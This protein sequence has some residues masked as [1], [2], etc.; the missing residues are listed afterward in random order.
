MGVPLKHTSESTTGIRLTLYRVV[1]WWGLTVPIL[2]TGIM[3]FQLYMWSLKG[4]IIL[5][6]T[7]TTHFSLIILIITT[8]LTEIVMFYSC[9]KKY[10]KFLDVSNTLER[11]DR[12]LQLAPPA[13]CITV[14]FTTILVVITATPVMAHI[15]RV[16]MSL[17][18]EKDHEMAIRRIMTLFSF[19]ILNC[20]QICM[21]FQFHEVTQCIAKRFILVN[22]SIKQELIIKSYR[23]SVRRRNPRYINHRED[24][25]SS[26]KMKS[27]MR[28]YQMLRDAVDQGNAFY[29]DLLMSSVFCKFVDVTIELFTFSCY[30]VGVS[31]ISILIIVTTLCH[32]C[33]LVLVVSSSSDVTQAADETAPIICKL[34]NKNLDAGLRKQL[35]TFLMQLSVH[36]VVFSARGCFKINRRMLTTLA[37]TKPSLTLNLGTNG[38]KVTSEPPPMAGQAGRL[39][40]QDRSAVTCPNSSHARRC[41]IWLSCDNRRTHYTAPLAKLMWDSLADYPLNPLRTTEGPG[42]N[43]F[44]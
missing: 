44:G 24:G 1:Y 31:Q 29:C 33:Y 13:C 3:S 18:F 19:A 11:F 30:I 7:N 23:Q 43:P 6:N 21:L 20:R 37:A 9:A 27:Y 16:Y 40:G 38:L 14:T 39:Q 12:S 2:Q 15:I 42:R 32:I 28:A 26:T 34:I 41:L 5:S 10:S 22:A 4:F 25:T 35:E 17:T 36:N 8:E